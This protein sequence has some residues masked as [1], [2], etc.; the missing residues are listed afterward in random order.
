M[1]WKWD[2]TFE[3][4]LQLKPQQDYSIPEVTAFQMKRRDAAI[5]LQRNGA[6][7]QVWLLPNAV[8]LLHSNSL[9]AIQKLFTKFELS[10]SP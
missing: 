8:G 5:F 1:G 9:S 4:A 3:R 2:T 6:L 10:R 7:H